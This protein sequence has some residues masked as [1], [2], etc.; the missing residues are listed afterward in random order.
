MSQALAQLFKVADATA[1]AEPSAGSQ[2]SEP[3]AAFEGSPAPLSAPGAASQA[4]CP[5]QGVS[6]TQGF[7][8]S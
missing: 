5:S 4:D 2:R 1:L 8:A 6:A 3:L 7:A